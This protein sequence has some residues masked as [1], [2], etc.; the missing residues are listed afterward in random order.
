MRDI[1]RMEQAFYEVHI[2]RIVSLLD[3]IKIEIKRSN[4]LKEK[5]LEMKEMELHLKQNEHSVCKD[6]FVK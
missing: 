4:A 6:M 3:D 1:T 5:E 2:P